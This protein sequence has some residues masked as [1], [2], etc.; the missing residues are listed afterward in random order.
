MRGWLVAFI[1]GLAVAALGFALIREPEAAIICAGLAT[2]LFLLYVLLPHGDCL[3]VATRAL[4]AYRRLRWKRRS[5][6]GPYIK[7]QSPHGIE[8]KAA[9]FYPLVPAV[10]EVEGPAGSVFATFDQQPGQLWGCTFPD[11]F[12][13]RDG[14]PAPP[15][16]HLLYGRYWAIFLEWD[17]ATAEL[18][19]VS[20]VPFRIFHDRSKLWPWYEN[21]VFLPLWM[22]LFGPPR[23]E[24]RP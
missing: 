4:R 5:G 21:R 11:E 20:K 22:K 1:S 17:A 23:K 7:R 3:P 10:C 6:W 16:N 18:K 8:L 12:Q 9:G 13:D 2:A 24:S 19:P 15:W 14:G